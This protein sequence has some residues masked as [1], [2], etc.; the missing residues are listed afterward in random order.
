MNASP[1]L[2]QGMPGSRPRD[3]RA[4][5]RKIAASR[6][7][8]DLEESTLLPQR[9]VLYQ[10]SAR[11]HALTQELLALRPTASRGG[12]GAYH[13]PRPRPLTLAVYTEN[14]PAQTCLRR[15][16]TARGAGIAGC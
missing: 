11:G 10:F 13:R 14:A 3:W 8:D 5:L 12:A 6:A 16:A 7:L 4:V 15:E 9:K 2:V 1:K